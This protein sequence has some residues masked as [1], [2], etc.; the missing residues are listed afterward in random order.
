MVN[1]KD[2]ISF[3]Q[4]VNKAELIGSYAN[5]SVKYP[6]DV[7]LQQYLTVGKLGDKELLEEFQ[8]KYKIAESNKDI[9]ITDFKCGIYKSEPLR[10]NKETIQLGYQVI[11]DNQQISF[12]SALNMVSTIKLDVMAFI[13][14]EF[15]EFSCNYYITHNI[16][17]KIHQSFENKEFEEIELSLKLDIVKYNNEGNYFKALKRLTA[18]KKL[19]DKSIEKYVIF[20]N[21]KVGKLNY[22]LNGIDIIVQ[23]MENTFREVPMNDIYSHLNEIDKELPGKYK[24]LEVWIDIMSQTLTFEELYKELHYIASIIEEDVNNSIL[25]WLKNK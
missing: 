3:L 25:K 20:F 16:D 6:S 5:K 22:L 4:I 13:N 7:D 8:N 14:K 10:W 11:N 9:Y 12:I 18:L 23:I 17:G 15:V 19:Q 2:I 24:N 1:K 21:S